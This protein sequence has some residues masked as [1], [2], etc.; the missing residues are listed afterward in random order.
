MRGGGDSKKEKDLATKMKRKVERLEINAKELITKIGNLPEPTDMPERDVRREI[1]VEFQERTKEFER[2][3]D[4][5]YEALDSL[6]TVDDDTLRDMPSEVN[7]DNLVSEI[8]EKT[9]ER[10]VLVRSLDKSLGLCTEYPNPSKGSV[11]TPNIF[12]G[13][14]GGNFYKFKEKVL[15]YIEAAQI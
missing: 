15:E 6:A 2:I 11:P 12:E 13:N 4:A 5:A 14:V 3:R 8:R 9:E 7:L 10:K 1:S